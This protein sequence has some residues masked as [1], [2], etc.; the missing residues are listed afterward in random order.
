MPQTIVFLTGDFDAGDL[1]SFLAK[2]RV[3]SDF[4]WVQDLST[5]AAAIDSH[6]MTSARLVSFCTGVIVPAAML[7]RFACGGYNIHPGPPTFPGRHPESW[8]VYLEAARFGATL[9]RMAPRVDEGEIIDSKWF[10]V[11]AKAGQRVLAEAAFKAAL[12]LLLAW[13]GRLAGVDAALPANGEVW[14]GRKWRRADLDAITRFATD[15]DEIEFD[16]RRRA[17][18]ELPGCTLT[19]TAHRCEFIYTVPPD[20]R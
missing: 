7:E 17:F 3:E 10:D 16:R 5:L 6:D 20:P 18:A 13:Y 11:P 1:C 9:H 2:Q 19:L 4:V 12:D 8:G 15:I 14:Q